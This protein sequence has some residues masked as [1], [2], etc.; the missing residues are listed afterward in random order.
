M[1][2]IGQLAAGVA[3]EFN[4]II[5][6]IRGNVEL[7]LN[8]SGNAIPDN[9]KQPLKDIERSGARAFDL[10]RQLLSFARQ[11]SPNVTV[12]DVNQVLEHCEGM[13]RRLI[14]TNITMETHLS[15]EPALVLAD[16]ADI[17]QAIVNLVLNARDAMPDGGTLTIRTRIV[18]LGDGDV[19]QDCQAG[20][21][22]QLSVA[23]N[24]CGMSPETVERIFEPFFTTK[25]VGRGTG[26]GLSTVYSDIGKSG[27]YISVESQTGTGTV[28]RLNLPQSQG[29]VTVA[30]VGET[31]NSSS[32]V[33]G[34]ETILVCDDEEIV[35]SSLAAFLESVGYSIIATNSAKEALVAAEDH[36]GDISMLFTDV[37]MPVMGGLDLGKE[38]HRR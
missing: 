8:R 28:V 6:V 26:L 33:G 38:I 3:H 29:L 34:S 5:V 15:A 27:G 7:L 13:L 20:Y 19:S 22:V 23:D 32:A 12:F 1:D 30:V 16:A 35:L 10:T 24:G 18:M 31:E 14:G 2:A 37:T 25:P 4:N 11:K 17:E 9:V 36:A 21:F